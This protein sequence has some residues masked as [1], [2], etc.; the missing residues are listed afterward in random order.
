M[1]IVNRQTGGGG[2]AAAV[3]K[4]AQLRQDADR[5][6]TGSFETYTFETENYDEGGWADIGTNNDRLTVPAGVTRV[7][8]SFFVLFTGSV[9]SISRF[10]LGIYHYNSA[11]V[12]QNVVAG[13]NPQT[14]WTDH[15]AQAVAL[16]ITCVAGDYFIVKSICQDSA[17]TTNYYTFTIQES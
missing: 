2:V 1:S 17:T 15:H 11:D 10:Q 12:L 3:L 9:L 8:I 13:T 14:G 16:G 7:N 6:L 5:V 4:T